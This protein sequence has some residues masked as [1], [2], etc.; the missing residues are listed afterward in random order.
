MQTLTSLAV[1]GARS[2]NN[3][4]GSIFVYI[5][6]PLIYIN[7][8]V[9]YGSDMIRP[10][11]VKIKKKNLIVLY[12]TN[13]GLICSKKYGTSSSM[14]RRFSES[15]NFGRC[16]RLWRPVAI[17]F[18]Y[19]KNRQPVLFH[20]HTGQCTVPEKKYKTTYQI[21]HLIQFCLTYQNM[22]LFV[23]NLFNLRY[24]YS[25]VNYFVSII[26]LYHL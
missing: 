15:T 5:F 19:V 8:Y 16:K 24:L 17:I 13:T 20:S 18:G 2:F 11:R 7:L 26:C 3:Q 1:W 22:I 4:T 10:F 14:Y 9:K 25:N 21:L 6:Y 23:I 12:K